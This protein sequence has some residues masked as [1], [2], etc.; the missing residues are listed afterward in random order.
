MDVNKAYVFLVW[1]CLFHPGFD[2]KIQEKNRIK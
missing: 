1:N 2:L